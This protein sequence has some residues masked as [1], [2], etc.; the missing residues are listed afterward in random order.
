[1]KKKS[2]QTIFVSTYL[3]KDTKNSEQ[4]DE[5]NT[6]AAMQQLLLI[7]YV[8]HSIFRKQSEKVQSRGKE[9]TS[10]CM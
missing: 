2:K 6:E 3:N 10:L 5:T 7:I 4:R 8:P 1:M 9:K